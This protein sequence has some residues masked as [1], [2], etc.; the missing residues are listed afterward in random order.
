MYGHA[1][2]FVNTKSD[3]SVRSLLTWCHLIEFPQVFAKKE[4]RWGR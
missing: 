2:R 3:F 4:R 1:W